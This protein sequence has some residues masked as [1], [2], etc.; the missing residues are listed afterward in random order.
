MIGTNVDVINELNHLTLCDLKGIEDYT[1]LTF[2]M[3]VIKVDL[4]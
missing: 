3:R 2:T 1:K 4:D